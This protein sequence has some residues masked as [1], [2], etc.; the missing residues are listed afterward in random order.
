MS[1]RISSLAIIICA[2][3]ACG[4]S[5]SPAP[6]G[7]AADC[8]IGPGSEFSNVCTVERVSTQSFVIHHPDGGFRRFRLTNDPSEPVAAAD[9]ALTLVYE[10]TDGAAEML[11]FGVGADRYRIGAELIANSPDE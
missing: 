9:G 5:A 2:L 6:K 4:S 7:A 1:L 3:T 8:A 10:S 11:E